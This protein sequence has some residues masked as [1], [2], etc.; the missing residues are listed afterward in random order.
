M[1]K[2]DR[3]QSQFGIFG[4]VQIPLRCKTK[5]NWK[6]KNHWNKRR[7]IANNVRCSDKD[8]LIRG[9]SF[10]LLSFSMRIM[11]SE[12]EIIQEFWNYVPLQR[13]HCCELMLRW[14]NN[15]SKDLSENCFNFIIASI[16]GNFKLHLTILCIVAIKCVCVCMSGIIDYIVTIQLQLF[17]VFK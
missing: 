14:Q 7:K 17:L 15:N 4:V 10:K 12:V 3:I 1:H 16:I 6:R 11:L 5:Y 2:I 9:Q 13:Q 8:P